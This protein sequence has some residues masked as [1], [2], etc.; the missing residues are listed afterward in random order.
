MQAL[1]LLLALLAGAATAV[2]A[3]INSQARVRLQAHFLHATLLNFGVGTSVLL[4]ACTIGAIALPRTLGWPSASL[5]AQAPPWIWTGGL[6][7]VLFVSSSVVLTPSLGATLFIV[8][9]IAGQLAGSLMLDEFAFL[10][11]RHVPVNAGRTAGVLLVFVGAALVAYSTPS[12]PP[13]TPPEEV[14]SEV[15]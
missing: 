11:G 12:K 7:G 3:V 1:P 15:R 14:K 5:I 8:L 6:L 10:G 13:P 4:L 2:Q 9:V